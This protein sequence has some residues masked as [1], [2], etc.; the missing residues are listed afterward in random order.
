M[1]FLY[2]V[3][4]RLESYPNISYNSLHFVLYYGEYQE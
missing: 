1:T 4:K 2:A 3:R